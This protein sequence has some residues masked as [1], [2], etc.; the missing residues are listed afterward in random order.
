MNCK[1]SQYRG[2]LF[3]FTL[4]GPKRAISDENYERK[5]WPKIDA[6]DYF[7]LFYEV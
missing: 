6:A 5:L 2:K 3:C 4:K 1:I 7:H